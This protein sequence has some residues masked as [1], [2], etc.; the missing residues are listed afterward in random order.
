M[1][2]LYAHMAR[3]QQIARR[4]LFIQRT[5]YALS[6]AEL[7]RDLAIFATFTYRPDSEQRFLRENGKCWAEWIRKLKRICPQLRYATVL[8][9]GELNNRVHLHSILISPDFP[10]RTLADPKRSKRDHHREL[11]QPIPWDHGFAQYIPIRYHTS[12]AWS[13]HHAWPNETTP[14]GIRPQPEGTPAQIAQ[15]VGRYISQQARDEQWKTRISR[16]YGTIR[17][18]QWIKQNPKLAALLPTQTAKTLKLQTQ[19]IKRLLASPIT[20]QLTENDFL[21]LASEKRNDLDISRIAQALDA[22]TN[23]YTH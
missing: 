20:K 9:R 14:T 16:N 17:I 22:M 7:Q 10:Q 2:A 1:A 8:Q 15:Y 5:I 13:K 12:D 23:S 3:N 21:K 4:N 19:H 6:E 18:Q 11:S